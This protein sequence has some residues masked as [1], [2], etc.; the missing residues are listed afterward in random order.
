MSTTTP[1]TFGDNDRAADRLDLLAQAFAASSR[2]FLRRVGELGEPWCA[3]DLGA[4][5]AHTTEL[6]AACVAPVR[7]VGFD[8]SPRLLARAR[9]RAPWLELFQHDVTR[10]PFPVDGVELAYAR[11][12]VT[13]L[14]SPATAL[15]TWASALAPVARVALEETADM[16]SDDPTFARYYEHVA[17]L[18]EHHRQDM[19]VGARLVAL[20]TDA[21]YHVEHAELAPV[22]LDA[23]VMARLHAMNVRTWREDAFAR[24][25]FDPR[26]LDA[27]TA[28]LD[29]VA[30][31]ARAAPPVTC[32]M[33]RV[34][35][36][37]G[38]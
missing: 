31:G 10:A 32:L 27:I 38:R 29:A 1:Y 12:L 8:L 25:A 28:D 33:G 37:L 3:A 22:V 5:L 11:F 24:R 16:R 17:A 4:G 18:Q 30:D 36:S 19:K 21:G 7:T 9:H 20:A 15:A 13:H 35:A 6:L 14:D 23:R 34:V 2:G 26:E